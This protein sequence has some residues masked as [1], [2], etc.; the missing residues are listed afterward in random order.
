MSFRLWRQRS[1]TPTLYVI[2]V[3]FVG[4]F[5]FADGECDCWLVLTSTVAVRMHVAGNGHRA[6]QGCPMTERRAVLAGAAFPTLQG[7]KTSEAGRLTEARRYVAVLVIPQGPEHQ[8][9]TYV[10]SG[11]VDRSRSACYKR[12]VS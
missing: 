6:T 11:S 7:S 1:L 4:E 5:T 12:P 8:D 2:L 3:V 9:L 10:Y